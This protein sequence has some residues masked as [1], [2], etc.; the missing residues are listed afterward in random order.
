MI[1]AN[2]VVVTGAVHYHG[3]DFI[4]TIFHFPWICII[5]TTANQYV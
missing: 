3:Y 2:S 5:Y 4:Q 1:S